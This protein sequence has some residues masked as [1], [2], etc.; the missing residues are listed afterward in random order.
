VLHAVDEERCHR[1]CD[2][3]Q[4]PAGNEEAAPPEAIARGRE[5]DGVDQRDRGKGAA[6]QAR[7]R[8]GREQAHGADH[9]QGASVPEQV[10]EIEARPHRRAWRGSLRPEEVPERVRLLGA[11]HAGPR[12]PLEVFATDRDHGAG[13]G[14]G[15]GARRHDH[16]VPDHGRQTNAGGTGA[17]ESHAGAANPLGR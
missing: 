13:R 2:R 7:E 12:R 4:E 11:D 5:H 8:Q 9:D 1:D 6:A 3:D 10:D 16:C 15:F 17:D 14:S